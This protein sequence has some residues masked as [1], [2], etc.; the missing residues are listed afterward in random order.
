[1]S[2]SSRLVATIAAGAVALIALTACSAAS[3]TSEG[4]V[5]P[6]TEGKFT[7]GTGEPAYA[8]WVIDD[9]PESGEGFEAAVGF[10]LAEELG[11]DAADVVWVRTTF[12]LAIAPGPKD[13]DVNVQQF[14]V[15][16]ER[17]NAVDFSTPYYETTQ[18]VVAATGSDAAN[19][20]TL[21]DLK[22]TLIGVTS[23][24]TSLQAV[25]DTIAP[26]QTTQVY[27][28]QD[29][30]V[31]ALQNGLVDAIVVDLPSAFFVRD[32]QLEGD[33]VIVGQLDAAAGDEFAFVLPKG[34]SLTG[35]VS[36]AVDALRER[37]VL[38]ELAN[39]WLADQGA[40]FLK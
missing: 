9:A 26:T 36:A 6:V 33:G 12:D 31:A 2:R 11:Y 39:T 29:D 20:T 16:E 23:G 13:F 18:A 25:E 1:M 7:I 15:T 8:P 37:G 14:S 3:D 30:A 28:T 24:T 27:N 5:G 19:A 38:A 21:A 34:S 40:P 4:A 32:V 17:K 22:D 35:E 10:A